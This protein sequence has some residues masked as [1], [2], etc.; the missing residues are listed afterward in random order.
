MKARSAAI[1]RR[2]RRRWR[3]RYL[4]GQ[5][6]P[7]RA[8]SGAAPCTTSRS[9]PPTMRLRPRWRASWSPSTAC[10]STEQKDRNYFRSIYFREPG[11]ILFEIATDIPGFAVDE[12]LATLGEALKL[13]AFL[14]PHRN[15]IEQALPALKKHRWHDEQS[16]LH[17]PLR[18]GTRRDLAPLLLLHGTGGDE[19]DLIPLGRMVAPDRALLSVRGKVLEGGAPRFFRRL[20]EGVFDEADIV[21]RAHELADF[22]DEATQ[23]VRRRGAGR[24]W[25][26][27]RCQHRSCDAAAAASTRRGGVL[28][29]AMA[30]LARPPASRSR[31]QVGAALVLGSRIPSSR[32]VTRK[33]LPRT[34]CA[35]GARVER[36]VLPVGHQL[37]QLDVNLAREW[38]GRWWLAR[39]TWSQRRGGRRRSL[40]RVT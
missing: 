6:F 10:T 29:R 4:R 27:Q 38:L 31:R 25:L 35:S 14:E 17:S 3:R 30:P 16:V 37:S 21:R 33:V 11:G 39:A 2:T 32:R 1:V 40:H 28:L 34:W 18:A 13:P 20:A 9:V 26:F 8:A 12:P 22:V 36:R 5:G 7:A 23:G 24:A 15:D 19:N